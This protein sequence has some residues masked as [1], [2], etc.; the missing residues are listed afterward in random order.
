MK[1]YKVLDEER[2]RI[3]SESAMRAARKRNTG[4]APP[5]VVGMGRPAIDWSWCDAIQDADVGI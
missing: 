3:G 2:D 5:L 4:P 1:G